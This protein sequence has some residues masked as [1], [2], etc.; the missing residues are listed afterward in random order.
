M[1]SQPKS[2]YI[3]SF[4]SGLADDL[5][6]AI[7][8]F[9][10]KTL[11]SAIELGN[12]Q[13][14]LVD[15]LTKKIKG[16]GCR[17]NYCINTGGQAFKESNFVPPNVANKLVVPKGQ[18]KRLTPAEMSARGKKDYVSIV[19]RGSHLVTNVNTKFSL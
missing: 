3:A 6:S 2:Y 14:A 16:G 5:K 19:M 12:D 7:K 10:L 1:A 15:A 8:T 13:S 9:R 4:F 18:I 17:K 11:Q